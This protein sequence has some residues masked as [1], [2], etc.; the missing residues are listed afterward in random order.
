MGTEISGSIFNPYSCPFRPFLLINQ[1]GNVFLPCALE[2][3]RA[4]DFDFCQ[5]FARVVFPSIF[6]NPFYAILE[7]LILPSNVPS[8]VMSVLLQILLFH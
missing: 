2:T 3:A 6:F 1:G 7:D 4:A 5:C 8:V